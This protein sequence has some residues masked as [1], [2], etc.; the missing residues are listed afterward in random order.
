MKCPRCDGLM[1]KDYIY[2][3]RGA[4]SHL[5]ILRCLN[6][7]ESFDETVLRIRREKEG[8]NAHELLFAGS[9]L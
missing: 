6:C 9:R 7:G 3:P 4:A 8:Q 1:V 2:D 5:E